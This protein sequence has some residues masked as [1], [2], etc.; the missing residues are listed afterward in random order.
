LSTIGNIRFIT[1]PNDIISTAGKTVLLDCE[2]NFDG[3]V[4]LPQYRWMIPE[5]Q[6]L[7]FI[8]DTRR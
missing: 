4:K 1:E 5:R 2:A 8:G 6:Y 3:V 7:D